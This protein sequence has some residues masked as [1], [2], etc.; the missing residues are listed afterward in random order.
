MEQLRAGD[1]LVV[2]LRFSILSTDEPITNT[3]VVRIN[4]QDT[5]PGDSATLYQVTYDGNDSDGGV[6][7]VDPR[8]YALG[9]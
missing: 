2:S 8:L 5:G 9:A 7:P 3:A 1:T 6:P 4:N